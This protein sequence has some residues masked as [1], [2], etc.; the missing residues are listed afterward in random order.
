[1]FAKTL[2][3]RFTK[4]SIRFVVAHTSAYDVQTTLNGELVEKI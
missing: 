3:A 1:M 2:E 4:K